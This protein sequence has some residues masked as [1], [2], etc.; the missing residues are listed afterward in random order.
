MSFLCGSRIEFSK[1]INFIPMTILHSTKLVTFLKL[2]YLER[3]FRS[4]TISNHGERRK[5]K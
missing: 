5:E 4:G 3:N 1:T 2:M